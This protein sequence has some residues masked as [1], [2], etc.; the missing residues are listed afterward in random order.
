M[1]MDITIGK[2]DRVNIGDFSGVEPNIQITLKDVDINKSE[3]ISNVLSDLCSLLYAKEFVKSVNEMECL[4]KVNKNVLTYR[5]EVENSDINKQH[6]ELFD[7][8]SMLVGE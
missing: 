4:V 7:K 3:E 2:T 5:D 8:L 1:K 6:K